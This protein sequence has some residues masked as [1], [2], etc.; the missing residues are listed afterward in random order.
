M[1]E[2]PP[3]TAR[4]PTSTAMK[5]SCC[6][7]ATRSSSWPSIRRSSKSSHLLLNGELPTV[8]QAAEF[9]RGVIHH[10][11]LHEQLRSFFNGFRRDAHPDGG[12]VRRGRRDV[13]LLS[14]QPRHQRSG[15]SPHQRLPADRQGPDD[16]RLD[17]QI[18][19]RAAVHVS[20]QRPR[21][22]RELPVHDE[23]G[24]GRAVP[25][26]PDPGAGHGPH[27]DPARRPRAERLDQH[28]AARRL[29]RRQPVR[30]HRRR[31]RQPVG[32]GAWRR[33][34]GGAEDAGRD[35][36]RRATSRTSSPR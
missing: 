3:A 32:A 22:C 10:T 5:A 17:L 9:E 15:T 14:R 30:L 26:Q 7:A 23:R 8:A 2:P 21:L 25:R 12:A 16:R 11:M 19:D 36:P 13:G 6:I 34:R 24:A 20:A 27:P 35:R 29:D 1:A 18:R 4:S 31:H 33:Q 28:G